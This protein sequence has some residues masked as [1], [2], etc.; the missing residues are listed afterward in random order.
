MGSIRT[1]TAY[2][3]PTR[4]QR[5]DVTMALYQLACMLVLS[6]ISGGRALQCYECN[7]ITASDGL[8]EGTRNVGNKVECGQYC[9]IMKMEILH[10]DSRHSSV[11]STDTRWR[12]GCT[13]DGSELTKDSEMEGK[14]VSDLGR[15]KL[16]NRSE[17]KKRII[18]TLCMCNSTLCNERN[19]G[20][21]LS[22][23]LGVKIILTLSLARSLNNNY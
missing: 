21:A 2:L 5:K 10:Y 4:L 14:T 8:C 7:G 18:H 22:V 6:L 15:T 12:R 16:G 23:P 20:W 3:A 1:L 19:S 13:T 17:D 11:V 9:G